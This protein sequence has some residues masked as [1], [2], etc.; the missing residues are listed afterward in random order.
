MAA[1]LTQQNQRVFFFVEEWNYPD[2]QRLLPAN[3]GVYW[4]EPMSDP[5]RHARKP[6]LRCFT[7]VTGA[8]RPA[9][10]QAL[11][12]DTVPLTKHGNMPCGALQP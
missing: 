10:F 4:S 8:Q 5:L 1:L 12:K 6:V 3:T 11:E 9:L 7:N 2:V